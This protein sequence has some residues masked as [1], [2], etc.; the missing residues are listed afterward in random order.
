[1]ESKRD[2]SWPPFTIFLT[3]AVQ[4]DIFL[5][6]TVRK[7]AD[8]QTLLTLRIFITGIDIVI[9]VVVTNYNNNNKSSNT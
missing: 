7:T 8:L 1:M 4:T 5:M 3:T 9:V 2:F 6:K